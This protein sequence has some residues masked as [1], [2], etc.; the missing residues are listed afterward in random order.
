MI[1]WIIEIDVIGWMEGWYLFIF[2]KSN[3]TFLL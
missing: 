3:K 1:S 2:F